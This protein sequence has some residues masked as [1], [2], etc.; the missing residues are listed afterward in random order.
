MNKKYESSRLGLKRVEKLDQ[1]WLVAAGRFGP[2][3]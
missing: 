1:P 2:A 3:S